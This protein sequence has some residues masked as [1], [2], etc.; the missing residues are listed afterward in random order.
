[1]KKEFMEAL[2]DSPII[3]AVKD[4][5]GLEKCLES[6]SR[7]IFILYGDICN[8]ADIVRKVKDADKLAMVHLDLIN[9]LSAKD[10]AV[11][12]IRKYTA[13]DG[14]ISTKPALVKHAGE[15]GMSSVLRLFVIDSMAYENIEKQ[16]K[17]ARPDVIE[18]LPAMMPKIVRKIC[19]ISQTPVIA[20]G[21]VTNKED[22]MLLLQAGV[23]SVS[24]TN[25]DIW[26]L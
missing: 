25:Q 1:M 13:A 22:V 3:A 4:D 17:T 6:D 14:I 18:I 10:I 23:V 21:L 20:G 2:E 9:G 24:S 8:I 26:F 19:K 12:F 7:V 11:D 16:V 15:L 5:R